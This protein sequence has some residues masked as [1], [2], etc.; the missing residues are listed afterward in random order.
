MRVGNLC[1]PGDEHKKKLFM[2]AVAT[3]K[4]NDLAPGKQ[5]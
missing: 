3:K 5:E 4:V 1:F 2:P